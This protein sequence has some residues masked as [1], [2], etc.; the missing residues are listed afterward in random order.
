ML[1]VIA[2]HLVVS[3]VRVRLDLIDGGHGLRLLGEPVQVGDLE[4]RDADAACPAVLGE[5]LEH[6]PGGDEVAVVKSGQRPVDQK[7]VDV[8]RTQRAQC[9]VECAARVIGPVIAVV[10]LAGDEHLAAVQPGIADPLTD[11]LLV[12]VHL[13]GVDVAVA[14]LQR[15]TYCRG[16]LIRLDLEDAETQLRDGVAVIEGDWRDRAHLI[17]LLV[18]A[19]VW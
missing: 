12:A 4:V 5:F 6:I 7:Q 9:V 17:D 2:A 10:E 15:R 3:E 13:G 14:D 1:A 18:V 16:S 8:I 19:V 11:L